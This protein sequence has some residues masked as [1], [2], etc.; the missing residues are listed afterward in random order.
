MNSITGV[1]EMVAD[2]DTKELT[3]TFSDG[4]ELIFSGKEFDE[5]VWLMKPETVY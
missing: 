5:L 4:T 2:H 1:I 3:I